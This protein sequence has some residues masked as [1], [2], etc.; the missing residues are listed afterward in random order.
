MK[1][2]TKKKRKDIIVTSLV[3]VLILS[4]TLICFL[5]SEFFT[6]SEIEIQ[7]NTILDDNQMIDKKIITNKNIFTYNL[8][9]IEKNIENNPYIE[10][11]KVKIKLPNKLI[12]SVKEV[13]VVALLSNGQDYCYIDDKGTNIEKIDDLDKNNGKIVVNTKFE[14]DNKNNIKYENDKS[15]EKVLNLITYLKNEHLDKKIVKVEY[16]R[17][18]RISM[19]TKENSKFIMEDNKDLEYNISMISKIIVDLQSKNI[20]DG[21]VDLTYGDYA[22][23][24]PS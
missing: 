2:S 21:I 16:E 19:L 12:I 5:K 4:T 24:K 10:E 18:K 14:L 11:A 17:N 7:G 3:F 6:L 13:E 1:K 20:K 15:K 23:Y 8:K 9:G 22:I